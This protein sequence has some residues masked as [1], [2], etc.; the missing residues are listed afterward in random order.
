MP[1]SLIFLGL[2]G[3]TVPELSC[4][5]MGKKLS[6][7]EL[8]SLFLPP[9]WQSAVTCLS[10]PAENIIVFGLAEGKVE[11]LVICLIFFSMQEL[12]GLATTQAAG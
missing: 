6:R 7:V 11:K 3:L 12:P 9:P 8:L 2:S 5:A 10:W 1:P 4:V